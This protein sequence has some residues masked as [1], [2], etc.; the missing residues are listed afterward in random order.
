[1]IDKKENIN[2]SKNI[3]NIFNINKNQYII[4]NKLNKKFIKVNNTFL[5]FSNSF[6]LKQIYNDKNMQK[7][8]I[9]IFL[10]LYEK[11]KTN[12][13][14][15]KFVNKEPIDIVIKYI[16]LTDK[17][18]NRKGIK[19][20][21]KDKDNEEL[22]YSTRSII[23]NIPWIRK[24]F[25][26]MPN[27]KVR[28]F[29]SSDEIKEKF[30]YVKDRDFLGYDSANIGAFTINL[31]KMENFGIS[32]N[33]IYMD[34]DYFIG[35]QLKK[36]D[37]FYYDQLDKKVYPYILC[38]KFKV[39]N[40]TDVLIK[41]D[42]LFKNKDRINPHS[43]NGF[44]LS[45]LSTEKFFFENYNFSLIRTEPTHN[46]IGLNIDDLKEIFQFIQKYKYIN[47]TLSSKERYIL[48]LSHQHLVNLYQLNI[49][50]KKIHSILH[51][52]FSIESLNKVKLFSPLYVL[53]TGGNHIPLNRQYKL[54]K[55]IFFSLKLILK[56]LNS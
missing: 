23:K 45:I 53:N 2:K 20:I 7:Y 25:I 21:Y 32:K 27:E 15:L 42:E 9:F 30:I 43:G 1:M 50:H 44:S 52:Y 51:K 12:T 29:K 19:Q 37:F 41:Y 39:I 11:E 34:D 24:I 54:Q 6:S 28:F 55:K 5:C 17:K 46:A 10:K 18:L 26:I 33:F 13:K 36:N 40:R 35:N 49:K 31:H 16:D 38:L 4:K 8:F 3:W 14:F 48:R 22:R 47:E 56:N